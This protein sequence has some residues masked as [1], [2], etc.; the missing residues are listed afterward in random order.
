MDVTFSNNGSM[1][2]LNT[3][4]S[5][6]M[7]KV[8]LSIGKIEFELNFAHACALSHK[9]FADFTKNNTANKKY[10]FNCDINDDGT[11]QILKDYINGIEEF[12]DI[13]ESILKDLYC[14]GCAIDNKDLR[15]QYIKKCIPKEI[16]LQNVENF[17]DYVKILQ[18][19]DSLFGKFTDFVI[20]HISEIDIDILCKIVE[21]HGYDFFENII[22]KSS[23]SSQKNNF[24][25]KMIESD[26]KY[27]RFVEYI[28]IS[29]ESTDLIRRISAVARNNENDC[30]REFLFSFLT[31]HCIDFFM[32][33]LAEQKEQIDS[34]INV[35]FER[36]H[37]IES[38]TN[39]ISTFKDQIGTL[40]IASEYAMI[41]HPKI[42]EMKELN[43]ENVNDFDKFYDILKDSCS[44]NDEVP[45]IYAAREKL[46]ERKSKYGKTPIL[47]AANNNNF[48]LVKMLVKYGADAS[49]RDNDGKNILHCFCSN[50]STNVECIVYSLQFVD[51]NETDNTVKTALHYASSVFNKPVVEFLLKQ[52]GINT[53]IKDKW[54]RAA[55][56]KGNNEI[57][58]IFRRYNVIK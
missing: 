3:L 16:T 57:K 11:Y 10:D 31:A 5:H 39:D 6:I 13:T 20:S 41:N 9:I 58:E 56:D 15:K 52:D 24:I 12:S 49:A 14:I 18:A 42:N 4:Q 2:V 26:L 19:E 23:N 17:N 7:P 47:W 8:H 50:S 25:T 43:N 37:R 29:L 22:I 33:T 32:K 40:T 35:N 30:D 21:N 51:I 53:S 34:L 28:D 48:D 55:Y 38:L 27:S 44:S 45:F 54:G 36:E 46:L 1:R